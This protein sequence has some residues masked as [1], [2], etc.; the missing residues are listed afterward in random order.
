MG[1]PQVPSDESAEELVGQ[2]SQCTQ[3]TAHCS[4]GS[5]PDVDGLHGQHTN[6]PGRNSSFSPSGEFPRNTLDHAAN[7]AYSFKPRGDQDIVPYVP[8]LKPSPKQGVNV[9]PPVSR[10]VGFPSN[11]TTICSALASS[12]ETAHVVNHADLSGMRFRKRMFSPLN[13]MVFPDSLNGDALYTGDGIMNPEAMG[14]T[15]HPGLQVFKKESNMGEKDQLSTPISSFSCCRDWTYESVGRGSFFLTDGPFPLNRESSPSVDLCSSSPRVGSFKNLSKITTNVV[16]NFLCLERMFSASRPSSPLGPKS[17]EREGTAI[18][19]RIF[20]RQLEIDYMTISG[21]GLSM[22]GSVAGTAFAMEEEGV[23]DMRRSLEE[24]RS[25][26]WDSAT[27]LTWPIYHDMAPKL[28]SLRSPRSL[29]GCCFR[30]SL[31]GSFEESLLS[32][33]F[34]SGGVYQKIDGFLAVLSVTRGSFSP[35]SQK[36]PFSVTSVNGD[37]YLLYYASIDLA[38]KSVGGNDRTK[39]QRSLSCDDQQS[40]KSR[41]RIP[42]KGRIQLV[43]SNPEKTP[44]HTFFCNYDLS[45]MPAGTKTFLRQKITLASAKAS[46]D[47][48]QDN[49]VH[50]VKVEDARSL[51]HSP[52]GDDTKSSNAWEVITRNA[53][54]DKSYECFNLGDS[55]GKGEQLSQFRTP[56]KMS[57]SFL[58]PAN[59]FN[60]GKCQDAGNKKSC[61]ALSI[62]TEQKSSSVPKSNVKDALNSSGALRYAIH[63][64]FLC[65]LAKKCS[66][67]V[68]RCKSD[69]LD[70]QQNNCKLDERER[71]FYLCNDLRVVFPQRHTDSD[72]GKLNVEYHFPTD[73]KYFDI[74]N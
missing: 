4:S 56:Q 68:Q 16:G 46:A 5:T 34:S 9:Y 20:R 7:S 26:S 35:K 11:E 38:G 33:R 59:E 70:L 66:K 62:A 44:V 22:D 41:L 74:G 19:R 72:E 14:K 58:L 32:G 24:F 18:G 31:V 55:T 10:I 37:S 69:P 28:Q 52:V 42:M 15:C 60:K 50:D 64:R 39:F 49:K 17:N 43:L 67:S 65:P 29:S 36:L 73:P 13:Q 1:L 2:L 63:L 61:E 71:R 27:G 25:S 45:D 30:R 21:V 48:Q 57:T 47:L 12:D 40:V 23:N 8:R 6:P 3:N 51:D 53:V 54:P